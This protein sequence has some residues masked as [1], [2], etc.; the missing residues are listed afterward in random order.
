MSRLQ[1]RSSMPTFLRRGPNLAV[2]ARRGT[3]RHS[4]PDGAF[5]TVGGV[6]AAGWRR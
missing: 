3:E 4:L 6:R 5:T 2:T 1:R